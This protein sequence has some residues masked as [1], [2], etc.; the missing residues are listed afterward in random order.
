[1]KENEE[2][3]FLDI[4]CQQS[5]HVGELICGDMFL[6]RRVKEDGRTVVVLSDGMG[7]GVKANVLATL[8]ASMAMNFTIEKKELRQTAEIIM[9][10]LPVCS[11]RKMSYSTFTIIDIEDNGLTTIVEYDNPTC[12][13]LRN[14]KPLDPDWQKIE[15]ENAKNKGKSLRTCQFMAQKEDRIF[16]WSDGI[17]QSGMGTKMF[18]FGWGV[19]GAVDY[20]IK[21][22]KSTP[23]ASSLRLAKKMVS[24]AELHDGGKPKDDTS[25]GVIYFREPRKLLL[26]TGPPFDEKNDLSFSVRVQQFEGKKI[27]AGGTTAEIV[28]REL[29][30]KFDI[31]M[32]SADPELPPTSIVEGINLV[33]EGILTLGKVHH[34][35]ESYHKDYR[36]G[37][38]PA[39]QIVKMF[40]ESD[41][42][43]IV[44]GTR[45]N[46]AHQ[47]PSLPVE[48]EIRR[49]VVKRIVHFIEEKFLKD[50]TIEFI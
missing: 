46:L 34:I 44:V 33:T 2:H 18:P 6:S 28:A 25:C 15:L 24:I 10:T 20:A 16:F 1:V 47:D 13:V 48:L 43:H 50:V 30:L 9:S 45:I 41:H 4:Y 7:S 11:V 3:F 40:Q 19:E 49:T 42:I 38:G 14:D 32:E 27:I 12:L 5:N 31:G 29:G 8:T 37:N 35:M 21:I 39:D 22:V 17:A 36:L 23:F 26:V